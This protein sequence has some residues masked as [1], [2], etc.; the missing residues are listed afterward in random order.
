MHLFTPLYSSLHHP[1]KAHIQEDGGFLSCVK[2]R[3]FVVKAHIQED[4]STVSSVVQSKALLCC[5][6]SISWGHAG[7][8]G[9][10]GAGQ[11][12]GR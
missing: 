3:F 1:I 12:G 8:A 2:Y 6:S 4:I 5:C 7:Q 9:R 11:R 10:E